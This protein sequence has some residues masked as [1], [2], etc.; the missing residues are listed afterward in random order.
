MGRNKTFPKSAK[1]GL[2]GLLAALV[3][4]VFIIS[5]PAI[6]ASNQDSASSWAHADIELAVMLGLVPPHLQSNY[7]SATTRA[8][9][10]ALGVAMYETFT[11]R[12]ITGHVSFADTTDINVG[13]M[14]YL[15]VVGGVGNNMFAPNSPLTREQ[16]ATL[17]ARLMAVMGHPLPVYAPT[18]ADSH[19]ISLW[20]VIAVGQVQAANI[21]GGVGNNMFSPQGS[22]TREQS[23]ITMLRLFDMVG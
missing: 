19:T 11:G 5:I 12:V 18:F 15:G 22:Y 9:F 1:N 4:C 17:T 6:A 13:K 10:A 20:A 3:V 16:A 2:K 23:I 8:E 21:M 14:A 7:T